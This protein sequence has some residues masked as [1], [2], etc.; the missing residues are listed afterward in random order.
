MRERD[1]RDMYFT[2]NTHS[3]DFEDIMRVFE[4]YVQA[5]TELEVEQRLESMHE[6]ERRAR[7]I[8]NRILCLCCPRC[9]QVFTDFEG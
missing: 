6:A 1:A 7:F 8:R 5:R 4:K 2:Y 9:Y 3:K